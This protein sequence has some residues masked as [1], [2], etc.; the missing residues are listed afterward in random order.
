MGIGSPIVDLATGMGGL[1]AATGGFGEV[2]E[3]DPEVGAVTHIPLGEPDDPF[4]P[5]V[6]AIGVG[7]GRVWAGTVEGLAQIDPARGV[8]VRRVDLGSG[9]L[10]I[11]VGGG[12]VWSTTLV[13]RATRI[14]ASSARMTAPFYAG[15][16]VDPIA[17]GGGAV[18]IGG[19]AGLSKVDPVTASPL[20]SSRPAP[21]VTGIAFGEGSV[22]VVSDTERSLMRLNPE[23]GDEEAHIE[24]HG[25]AGELVVDSGLVWVAVQRPD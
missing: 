11:A 14:E 15:N 8:V 18:W 10:Q 2:V 19:G 25:T 1:W 16:W 20:F 21:E 4:V 3:I 22:W 5:S 12:A 13:N 23:T 17:L 7:D 9:V 24:L 6:S